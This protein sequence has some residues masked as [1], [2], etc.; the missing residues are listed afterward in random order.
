M[1]T[2]GYHKILLYYLLFF[3]P[4]LSN[5]AVDWKPKGKVHADL[6]R[7]SGNNCISNRTVFLA[8]NDSLL[9]SNDKGNTWKRVESLTQ[10][11]IT[12]V[13][14]SA[15]L[16]VSGNAEKIYLS[17]D[18][19]NTWF[20]S[21]GLPDPDGA[22][23]DPVV[24]E[25]GG[26][27]F[28]GIST[29]S[30]GIF[31]VSNVFQLSAENVW[32]QVHHMESVIFQLQCFGSHLFVVHEGG[33]D[34]IDSSHSQEAYRL[35][36]GLIV[37]CDV[38]RFG[39]LASPIAPLFYKEDSIFLI[40]GWGAYRFRKAETGWD[41]I[42]RP[43]QIEPALYKKIVSCNKGWVFLAGTKMGKIET[44]RGSGGLNSTAISA[45]KDLLNIWVQ[46]NELFALDQSGQVFAAACP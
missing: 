42:D 7:G 43:F 15:R 11:P 34:T 26:Q 8:A 25:C 39:C 45:P 32:K 28:L 37:K 33:V 16:L 10:K 24:S 40:S 35:N 4:W 41:R 14:C 46:G 17:K 19:G 36:D 13:Y 30:T 12:F 5:Y 31:I 23:W 38:F 6:S 21:S 2:F 44:V 1:R 3:V 9:Q 22:A 27:V 29:T 20:E 18:G